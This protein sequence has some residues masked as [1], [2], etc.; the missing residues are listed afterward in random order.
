[1]YV[2]HATKKQNTQS[3][4]DCTGS[5]KNETKTRP[6]SKDFL[7]SASERNICRILK[8]KEKQT[9]Q[10]FTT[11]QFMCNLATKSY[12]INNQYKIISVKNKSF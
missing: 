7:L 5:G 8:K 11:I 12:K 4:S 2:N 6:N 9:N 3:S 1:M 10:K